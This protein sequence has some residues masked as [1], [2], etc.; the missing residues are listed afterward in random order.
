D[1]RMRDF[2]PDAGELLVK[3][4]DLAV[5]AADLARYA[6]AHTAD[7]RLRRLFR[8]FA[9]T[10]E[11]Q[12]RALRRQLARAGSGSARPSRGEVAPYAALGLGVVAALA[13][14]AWVIV[15]RRTQGGPGGPPAGAA[16]G[17]APGG[18]ANRHAGDGLFGT[19]RG[20]AGARGPGG[21]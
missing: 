16:P 11:H 13:T 14:A 1:R 6:A 18:A 9:S 10:S 19:L 4:L 2:E 20:A 21:A 3:A 5:G 17:F 12:E 7:A 8:Q 15:W